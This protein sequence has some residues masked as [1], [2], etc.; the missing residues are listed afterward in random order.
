MQRRGFLAGILAAG[1][2]P[3]AIGSGVLMPVK[4]IQRLS[5]TVQEG[6]GIMLINPKA[7]RIFEEDII[8]RLDTRH[9][10]IRDLKGNVLFS[11][12]Y[13]QSDPES[14]TREVNRGLNSP[15]FKGQRTGLFDIDIT[16]HRA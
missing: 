12:T 4:K 1:F 13:D 3:A 5:W 11:S 10:I 2:A 16:E 8:R 9:L 15:L 6:P 7:I 14:Y